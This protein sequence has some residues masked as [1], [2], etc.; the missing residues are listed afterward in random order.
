MTKVL[1]FSLKFPAF[2]P[3]VGEP[4]YFV[5]K[6]W[7]GLYDAEKSNYIPFDGYWQRYEEIFP[8]TSD[9]L[10]N[11][12]RHS[13]KWHTIRAGY[14]WK[15]GDMFSPRVWSGKPYNSPQ[16][17]IAPD[18]MVEKVWK[19]EIKVMYSPDAIGGSYA[20]A[21]ID[22]K[23]VFGNQY[24]ELA[25]NDGLDHVDLVDWLQPKQ[26]LTPFSGQIICWNP[27]IEY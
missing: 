15:A 1:T 26:K 4:T 13:P 25:K 7:K 21:L 8:I 3:K 11:I 9:P 17:T 14:N 12:H 6:I 16:I 24:F 10:E 27:A 19:F 18:I 20:A 5:E 22:D 2:H 23:P